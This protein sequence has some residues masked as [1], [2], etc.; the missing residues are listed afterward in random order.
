MGGLSWLAHFVSEAEVMSHFHRL[1]GVHYWALGLGG[2]DGHTNRIRGN[3]GHRRPRLRRRLSR[4]WHAYDA[5][6][7]LS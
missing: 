6:G 7:Y 5:A 1:S 3:R 4:R 2:K